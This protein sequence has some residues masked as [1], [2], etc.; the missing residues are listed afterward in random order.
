MRKIFLQ[1]GATRDGHNPYCAVAKR[2]GYFTVLAE[3]GDFVDYQSLSLTLP[4]DLIVR[5]DRPENPWEVIQAYLHAGLLSHPQVVLAGFEAYNAS[6]GRVREMLAGPDAPAAFIPLD[7]YAQRMALKK[8]WPAFPQPEFRFFASPLSILDAKEALLYPCVVKPVDGG[9]GL[10]IWLI[11]RADQ[12]CQVVNK[13]VQTMNYGGR[14]FSGFIVESGL[15]G[16]E[17]SLQ[18]V[19]HQ[20]HPQA[21]TCCQK[22]IEQHRDAEGCV[23]FYES[24][25]VALAAAALPSSFTS[26]MAF[27]CETFG[28]RQGAFHIDFILVNGIPH[29]LEMGFRLS[30]MGVTTLVQEATGIDWADVTFGLEA[31]AVLPAFAFTAPRAVGQLRLRQPAQLQAAERWIDQHQQGQLM[32]TLRLPALQVSPRSSLYADL[33]R[34]AGVLATFCLTAATREPIL[35]AFH[36]VIAAQPAAAGRNTVCAE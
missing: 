20:G 16:E 5:L 12:L 4:F 25:H 24:G 33:T 27:C 22:V 35:A 14:G 36:Q 11:E 23:S 6:A 9:G 32:P 26:L 13:L 29:F 19:V 21:L 18:G 7:K 30:G 10:G 3:M 31:G 34:H 17:F 2:D 8:A 28:Y 1:I 15:S